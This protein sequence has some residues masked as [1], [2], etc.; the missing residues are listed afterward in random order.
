MEEE[1]NYL[2]LAP[3][4]IRIIESSILTFQLF[5]KMDKKKNSGVLNLFGNQNPMATPLQQVQS[6]LEKV[7]SCYGIHFNFIGYY[8]I[9][10]D[11]PHYN[12]SN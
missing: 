10:Y 3:D 4:I 9:T 1:P 6:L 12:T 2:V 8:L 7:T 5:V 11:C